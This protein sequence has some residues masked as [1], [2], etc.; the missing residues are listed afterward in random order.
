MEVPPRGAGAQS[1]RVGA[2]SLTSSSLPHVRFSDTALVSQLRWWE[3]AVLA[4]LVDTPHSGARVASDAAVCG[5]MASVPPRRPR[6]H[7]TPV[8][9]RASGLFFSCTL[10]T[11]APDTWSTC[12]LE[13][14][15]PTK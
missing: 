9:A 15:F 5:D 13:C 11:T 4:G 7:P 14:V 8:V 1:P 3:V 12:H 2:G 10:K 6:A